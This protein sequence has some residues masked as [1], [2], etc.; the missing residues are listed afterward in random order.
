MTNADIAQRL[1][2]FRHELNVP[3]AIAAVTDA[4]D[5]VGIEV[6]GHRS[7]ADLEPAT[8]DDQWHIGS[9]GKSLTALLYGC[10]VEADLASWG[11]PISEIFDDLADVDSG[12]SSV[13]IDDVLHG[14]AGIQPNLSG[15]EMIAGHKN[16]GPITNQ[17]TVAA[18]NVLQSSPNNPGRFVYSNLG[19]TIVGAAIDRLAGTSYEEAMARY[20]LSPLGITTAGFGAPPLI[21]GHHPRFR[22]GPLLLGQGKPAEP[23]GDDPADNPAVLSPAGRMHLSVPDWAAIIRVF[24]NGGTPLV[25]SQTIDHLLL[26]PDQGGKGRS[27]SMGWS[28]GGALGATHAMQ[29][30]NT[31][32]AATVLMDR[33][34]GRAALTVANDGRMKV[35]QGSAH[36]AS[37]MLLRVTGD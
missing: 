21:R 36:L 18:T 16:T 30:S 9:C 25:S 13:T 23:D 14:R 1:H 37:G 32:W 29:G 2:H 20:V 24:L 26:D 8:I 3:A 19:Y 33:K 34:S 22:L 15:S 17:R 6:L 31:M 35:I 28:S 7:R 11:T 4:D 12:W 10:L 5:L 27:M